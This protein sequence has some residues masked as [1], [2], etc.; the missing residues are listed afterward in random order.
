M[1]A[2]GVCEGEGEEGRWNS[3]NAWSVGV[4]GGVGGGRQRSRMDARGVCGKNGTLGEPGRGG[5]SGLCRCVC[6][7]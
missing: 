3:K 5:K 7:C 4:G 2:W 6:V 1:D